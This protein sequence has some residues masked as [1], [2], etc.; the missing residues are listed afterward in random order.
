[1]RRARSAAE[2]AATSS[3]SMALAGAS[4]VVRFVVDL[5][6]RD[7]ARTPDLFGAQVRRG[8]FSLAGT[9][10]FEGAAGRFGFL[11]GRSTHADR[12][13]AIRD[14]H[15]RPGG[16]LDPPPP[17]RVALGPRAP[18][19]GGPPHRRPGAAPAG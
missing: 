12:V 7:A 8:G 4:P 9:E 18:G 17:A 5:L 16:P 11:S 10:E 1:R 3:P 19:P 13:P 14:A 2:T 6:G 15:A